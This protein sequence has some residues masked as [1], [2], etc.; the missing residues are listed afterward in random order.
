ME[1]KIGGGRK[2]K[3]EWV[4][5]SVGKFFVPL[6]GHTCDFRS[7]DFYQETKLYFSYNMLD[8]KDRI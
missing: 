5:I 1:K 3:V 2:V 4:V 6:P 8:N 7:S